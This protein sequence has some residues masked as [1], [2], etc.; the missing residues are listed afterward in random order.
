MIKQTIELKV[1]RLHSEDDEDQYPVLASKYYP[2]VYRSVRQLTKHHDMYIFQDDG[3]YK[4]LRFKSPETSIGQFDIITWPGYLVIVGDIGSGYV[5]TADLNMIE[6]FRYGSGQIDPYYWMG[7]LSSTINVLTD[8]SINKFKKYLNR[9]AEDLAEELGLDI[10][11]VQGQIMQEFENTYIIDERDA[12]DFVG[13]LT[14]NGYSLDYAPE[15]AVEGWMDFRASYLVA[16]HAIAWA[17]RMYH[18]YKV[19]DEFDQPQLM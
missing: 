11:E 13:G 4:H 2:D 10:A 16:C 19:S 17:A 14:Y 15:E 1:V 6:W 12:Y 5:F 18:K 9:Q 3:L 7:K 8:F